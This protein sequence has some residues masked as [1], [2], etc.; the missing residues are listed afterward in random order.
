MVK[1]KKQISLPRLDFTE[2]KQ[3][4]SAVLIG[5]LA[6]LILAALSYRYDWPATWPYWLLAIGIVAGILN[7][8][9]EEGI[10]FMIS[11]LTIM[12]T[13]SLLTGMSL[14]PEWTVALYNSVIYMLAPATLLVG[15]KVLYAL[16]TK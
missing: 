14:F 6:A 9:H 1:T 7:I 15:L 5:M 3:G 12:F 13:L 4:F 11:S 10:L 16:A 8:F 2:K